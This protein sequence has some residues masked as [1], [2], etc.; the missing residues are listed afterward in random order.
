MTQYILLGVY[1]RCGY[2]LQGR[3][4]IV[5]SLRHSVLWQVV[6]DDSEEAAASV[7]R[8]EDEDNTFAMRL[9]SPRWL[10]FIIA[11]GL[12]LQ[13]KN[14]SSMLFETLVTNTSQLQGDVTQM[15][16]T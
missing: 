4:Q 6:V 5:G 15:R 3:R 8:V 13:G 2:H 1:R 12:H 14:G 11:S 16:R 10:R 9:L 7:F